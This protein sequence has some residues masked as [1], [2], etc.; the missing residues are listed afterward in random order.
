MKGEKN[1]PAKNPQFSIVVGNE[2]L[3]KIDDFQFGNRYRSRSSATVELIKI[4]MDAL[5]GK[6]PEEPQKKEPA[7]SEQEENLLALFRRLEGE[8]QTEVLSFINF[9]ISENK[10]TPPR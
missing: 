10:T 8:K 4:A 2:L 9:K 1:M 7:L 6:E 3:K 5:E